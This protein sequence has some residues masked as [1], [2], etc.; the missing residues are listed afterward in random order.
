MVPE[1]PVHGFIDEFAAQSIFEGVS[2]DLRSF[3]HSTNINA[4]P[5]VRQ[6]WMGLTRFRQRSLCGNISKFGGSRVVKENY[7]NYEETAVIGGG[8]GRRSAGF[9]LSDLKKPLR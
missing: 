5:T 8:E 9:P 4:A 2:S 7:E 1:D 6:L 3:S